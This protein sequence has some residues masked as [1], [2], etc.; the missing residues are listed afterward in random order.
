[1]TTAM[2]TDHQT[3]ST[4]LDLDTLVLKDHLMVTMVLCVVIATHFTVNFAIF[5]AMILKNAG[6]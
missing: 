6:N 4:T 2:T 3:G 5:L 1:M